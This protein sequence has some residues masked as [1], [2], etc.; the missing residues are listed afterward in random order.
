MAVTAALLGGSLL[1][2]SSA[3]FEDAFAA[4]SGAHLSASFTA[5]SDEA[6]ATAGTASA[7]AGP[8][9]TASTAVRVDGIDLPPVVVVG[10]ADPQGP[11]DRLAVVEGE[12]AD[13]PGE[14][15]LATSFPMNGILGRQ[16]TLVDLPGAPVVKVVG[17][18]RSVTRTAEAWMAPSVLT[19]PQGYQM[20]Y[21]LAAPLEVDAAL[22]AVTAAVPEGTVA[23]SRS[24]L[25]AK[26]EAVRES[27]LFVPFLVAFGVLG[28]VMSVLVVGNV[29]AGAVG[30]GVRRIGVLKALGCTPRQVVWTYVGQ[31]LVPA[32]AGVALGVLAGNLL[33]IPVLGQTEEVYDA[34][35]SVPLWIDLAV[36]GGVLGVVTVTAWVSA[37]RAG[38]LRTVEAL[39]VGRAGGTRGRSALRW[40]GRLPLPFAL[41]LARPFARPARAFGMT[42]AVV[43]G[44]AAVTFAVG[45]G[46]SLGV[47]QSAR[48]Y[49]TSDVTVGPEG[50]MRPGRAGTVDP[51]AV[52][53]ALSAQAGTDR[54]F[55][56]ARA[57]MTVPG[58][59]GFS[60]V[61][62][63]SGD[64]SWGGHP[65]IAG[66]WYSG[67]GEA[68][69]PTA[70]L[71]ATGS[72]IG[73]TVS[74]QHKG[75]SV[76]V[77]IVGEL[78]DT[79]HDGLAVYVDAGTFPDLRAEK[80]FVAVK[81]G[82]DVQSYVDKLNAGLS[83]GVSAVPSDSG[84]LS[85]TIVVIGSLTALL[86]LL[87]VTVSGLG[88]LN[89]VLLDTR[90]RVRDLGIH[91]ALGMTPRQTVAVVVSSVGLVGVVGGAVGVPLG[92]ALHDRIVPAMGR[93]AGT[94]LPAAA[95]TVY[96]PLLLAGLVVG[97]VVIAVLG[98]LPP[99]GWAARTRT[100][101]ALRTE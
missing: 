54:Y 43:F 45:L 21:R 64:A 90:D 38:R 13:G 74:L 62:A 69:V 86:T 76:P 6:A 80:F 57:E 88:V 83:G 51:A 53:A 91:K 40:F 97:G 12:W 73:D 101:T 94:N 16:I 18:A 99:A 11:V 41:G 77:R 26:Q 37:F 59:A 33:A 15:V 1:V 25:T 65:M 63:Y 82:T 98:A 35:L 32:S 75:Q 42:A 28:L 68:V 72:R 31:A 36:V 81:D 44:T 78:F 24:W 22:A 17:V 60:Q 56:L 10:R 92:M 47:V 100:A 8:F 49:D 4:Q 14:I 71:N 39:A 2:V 67:P 70:F 9:P 95:F 5:T 87:L 66:S 89:T 3:P 46:M 55:G 34:S 79:R 84:Q 27:A 29:V 50:P 58:M 52:T 20:L 7:S 48:D 85:D 96:T 19:A 30:S 61:Y 23:G 93:G